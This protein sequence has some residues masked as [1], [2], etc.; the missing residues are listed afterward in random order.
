[1]KI[2]PRSYDPGLALAGSGPGLVLVP[3][4]AG[5]DRLFFRQAPELAR[6]YRVATYS[7]RDSATSMA[8]LVADLSAVVDAASPGDRRAFIVGESFGGALALSFAIAH[9]EQVRG[10]VILNSFPYFLPQLRLHL[11]IAGIR[12]LPWGSMPLVRRLTA[13][14]LHSRHTH[15]AEI[16]RFL[17]LTR[18]LSRE[19]YLGRLRILMRYDV[20]EQL[21]RIVAPT[22]LLAAELDHLVPSPQQARYMGERI[23]GATVRILEGHGHI[24]LIARDLS[25]AAI[26]ADWRRA[27]PGA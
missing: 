12:L 5:S 20:R 18:N 6:H 1:M 23:P 21:A 15:A 14:R 4:I 8:E 11:A 7:L 10:L 24:C 22:L 16:E 25:L 17:D 26:L 13:F 2:D 19:G 27:Q 3:G 9:P